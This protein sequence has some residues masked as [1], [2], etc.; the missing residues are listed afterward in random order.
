MKNSQIRKSNRQITSFDINSIELKS[1]EPISTIIPPFI[2]YIMPYIYYK[3]IISI[4][5][6]NSV[7]TKFMRFLNR[8]HI[9]ERQQNPPLIMAMI[10]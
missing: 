2:D 8:S 7:K 9:K 1:N 6:I 5:N 3:A 10:R 4:K